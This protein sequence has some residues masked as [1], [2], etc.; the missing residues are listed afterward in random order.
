[1]ALPASSGENGVPAFVRLRDLEQGMV[2]VQ[3]KLG[4]QR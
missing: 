4:F 1:V 2:A 3:G